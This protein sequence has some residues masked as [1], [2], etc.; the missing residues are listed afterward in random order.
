MGDN[1]SWVSH[2]SAYLASRGTNSLYFRVSFQRYFYSEQPWKVDTWEGRYSISPE[3]RAGWL[4]A[5]E[6][7]DDIW[8]QSQEPACLLPM[9]KDSASLSL[10]F[11]SCNSPLV[12]RCHQDLGAR[13]GESRQ[14]CGFPGCCYYCNKL[15]FVS[16]P[17]SHALCIHDTGRLTC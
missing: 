16:C 14:M 9:M 11:L 2:V 13:P 3:Q 4:I 5:L 17:K 15:S 8:L 6:G 7:R 10:G 1:T 12:C